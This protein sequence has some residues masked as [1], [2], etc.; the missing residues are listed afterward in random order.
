MN[1]SDE[2]RKSVYDTSVVATNKR[3]NRR[4][5]FSDRVQKEAAKPIVLRELIGRLIHSGDISGL[6]PRSA[7]D[8]EMVIRV[9]TR[10][11]YTN[12]GLGYLQNAATS[13]F[14]EEDDDLINQSFKDRKIS[15]A[16]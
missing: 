1:E 12:P 4:N 11:A 6:V 3:T 14:C 10:D 2:L 16:E 9:R 8:P 7:K 15:E 13:V 5:T